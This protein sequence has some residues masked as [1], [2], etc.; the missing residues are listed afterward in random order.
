MKLTHLEAFV[1]VC[2]TG[3][4]TRAA[5]HLAIT[6]SAASQHV[7]SLEREL[8]VQLLHRSTRRQ[9]LTESGEA[10]LVDARA[11][12]DQAQRLAEK[13]RGQAAQLTGVLRLTSSD[14]TATWVAPVIAEYVRLHPGMQVEYRPSDH[15]VDLVAEG[16]DLS[17][18]ATGRRDSSLRAAPL[19]TFD[20][21][22]VASPDYLREHG[23]PKQLAALAQHQWIA[24]TPIPQPWTVR[25]RDGQQSVHLQRSL[26]TSSTTGGRALA[27]AGAG[28]FGAP[29]LVVENEVASGQLVRVLPHVKLP[30]V[31]LY[32]AWPGRHEPPLKTR[33]FIELAKARLR[34]KA[35]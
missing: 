5:E 10:L 25:T 1:A 27:L 7:A 23:T 26:S 21:W 6:K 19:A 20:V 18:R 31:F 4:F 9:T 2:T 32:A 11:L 28:V 16:M 8:G 3:S 17:V 12:L 33:A 24:F 13:T 35:R 30:Q 22:C 14:I 29:S 15:L 34:P